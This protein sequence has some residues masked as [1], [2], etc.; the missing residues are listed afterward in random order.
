MR[1]F[2][3]WLT[4]GR[5]MVCEGDA[6][7]DTVVGRRVYY[8]RDGYGRAWLAFGAWDLFRVPLTSLNRSHGLR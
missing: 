1:D 2:L 5:P 6:F 4:G 7:T 3:R 8:W